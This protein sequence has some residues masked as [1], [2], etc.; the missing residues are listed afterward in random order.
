MNVVNDKLT[1]NIWIGDTGASCHMRTSL[2]GMYD[3]VPGSGG[4]KVGRGK[5][6]K[7]VKV[8]KFKDKIK[9]KDSSLKVIVLNEVHFVPDMY[10]DLFSITAAMDEGFR[11]SGR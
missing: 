6:L 3:T 10:C 4:I 5:I 8:R 9:Q 1:N 11:L 2:D 7:I